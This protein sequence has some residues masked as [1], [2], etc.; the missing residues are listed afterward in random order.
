MPEPLRLFVVCGTSEFPFDRLV[1]WARECSTEAGPD[2]RFV[3]Q[4]GAATPALLSDDVTAFAYCTREE[5]SA[6]LD[7]ADAIVGHAG[8]GLVLDVLHTGL[9]AA[10]VP[11]LRRFG[12]HV[13]DHQLEIARAL[14]IEKV[15]VVADDDVS[16]SWPAVRTLALGGRRPPAR[17]GNAA[18]SAAIAEEL[19]LAPR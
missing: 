11:R 16:M 10:F 4:H 8:L 5:Y 7:E 1:R 18:L 9:P 14:D 15:S 6:H 2:A 17:L 12:E 19:G 13:D 3:V